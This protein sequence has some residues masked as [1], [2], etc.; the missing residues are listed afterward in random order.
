MS[1][2]QLLEGPDKFS[3]RCRKRDVNWSPRL[4]V[5]K[6]LETPETIRPW[7]KKGPKRH[8]IRRIRRR[9]MRKRRR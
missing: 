2:A 1:V 6:F 8:R 9:K 4:G 7:T 5:G 3:A